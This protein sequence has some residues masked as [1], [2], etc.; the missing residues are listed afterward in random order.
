MG[1]RRAFWSRSFGEPRGAIG[2]VG[3]RMTGPAMRQDT[4]ARGLH[5]RRAGQARLGHD[6]PIGRTQ[7]LGVRSWSDADAQQ[8]AEEAGFVD[9]ALSVL[10]VAYES[11]LV[12]ATRLAGPAAVDARE[13]GIAGGGRRLRAHKRTIETARGAEPHGWIAKGGPDDQ[14][15]RSHGVGGATR[16][17]PASC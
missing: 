13:E 15:Q 17:T 8:P 16:C 3:A 12:H 9:V 10:P 4:R 6:R 5:H 14:H 1:W 2:W 7:C 11:R